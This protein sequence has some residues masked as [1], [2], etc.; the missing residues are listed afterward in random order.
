MKTF[1]SCFG[2]S[3]RGGRETGAEGM[4]SGGDDDG[5]DGCG[6]SGGVQSAIEFVGGGCKDAN[7]TGKLATMDN[8]ISESSQV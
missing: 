7:M 3:F 1:T 8:Q 2:R 6:A 4:V 5:I